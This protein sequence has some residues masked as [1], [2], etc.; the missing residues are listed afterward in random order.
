M[1][2]EKKTYWITIYTVIFIF[3]YMIFFQNYWRFWNSDKGETPFQWDADQYYSYL[4]ATFIYHDL[5]F[6]YTTRYWLIP[7]PNGKSVAKVTYGMALM[8]SPFFLLG[9][10][11]AINQGDPLDGYSPPYGAMVHYGS[12]FYS[13]MGLIFLGLVLRRFYSD[14]IIALTITT[15]FFATNLFYYTMRDG[16]MTHAYSFFLISIF[17]WLTCRW[18]ERQKSIYFLWLGL[19]MGLL[20]LIRP[21]EILIFIIFLGYKVTSVAELK[22]K[23]KQIVFSLKNVPMFLLGFFIMWLPQMIYWKIKAGTFLFFSYGSEEKFFWGD[24]QIINLLFSYRKGWFIYTPVMLFAVIGLLFILKRKENT[25][26]IPL[27]IYMAISIYM[28]SCWWCWWYG[29]SFGMRSFVQAY[30]FLAIPLAAFYQY[31][32][33]LNFKKQMFTVIARAGVVFLFSSFTCLNIIQTYQYDHPEGQR[34]MHY[35]AMSKAAYWR[36]FGKFELSP[37]EFAKFQ[38]E[39]IA[40]DYQA[41]QKGEKRD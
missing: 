15:V 7:A 19:V 41:A 10:K 33:S 11:I 23:L 22:A 18:H 6:S 27:L 34:L 35:D 30:V 26:K 16:E 37:E 1:T 32:F 29:G 31:M 25:F 39:L 4:P 36:V 21:T 24:P 38:G 20:T 28:L 13:L 40:P 2:R 12:L 8:Y 17:L 9:H 14:K 5:D 3:V